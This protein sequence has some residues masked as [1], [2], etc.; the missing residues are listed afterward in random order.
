MEG[1]GD[2][3]VVYIS[4]TVLESV[5]GDWVDN[6]GCG[7][8]RETVHVVIFFYT[9]EACLRTGAAH[10]NWGCE[11]ESLLD[12]LFACGNWGC[13]VDHWGG[14]RQ[15]QGNKRGG[16]G[17]GG[18]GLTWFAPCGVTSLHHPQ[19]TLWPSEPFDTRCACA[20][21]ARSSFKVPSSATWCWCWVLGGLLK[22]P[23]LI[24]GQEGDETR[25][26]SCWQWCLGVMLGKQS[27]CVAG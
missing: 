26:V 9:S 24:W 21:G 16:G 25:C 13:T 20:L 22:T 27:N 4:H 10:T 5:G 19:T 6:C 12:T 18:G 2:V 17:R 15:K 14:Q 7:L 11:E 8:Q 1:L 3:I 23:D